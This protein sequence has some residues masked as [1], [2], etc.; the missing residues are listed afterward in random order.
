MT[1]FNGSR[2]DGTNS[3][4][5]KLDDEKVLEMRRLLR[6]GLADQAIGPLF[7]VS[8]STVNYFAMDGLGTTSSSPTRDT[9]MPDEPTWL[10]T[11]KAILFLAVMAP[12]LFVASCVRSLWK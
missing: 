3:R 5:A 6:D 12:F 4:V 2:V 8:D 11:V 9:P 10:E 7:D 1:W